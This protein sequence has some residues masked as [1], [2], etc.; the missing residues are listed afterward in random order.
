MAVVALLAGCTSPLQQ[1]PVE[2]RHVPVPAEAVVPSASVKPPPGIE[3]AGKPGYYT[4]KPGDT[5]FHISVENKQSEQD[6]IAWNN[7]GDPNKIE[8]GQVLRVAPPMGDT[9]PASPAAATTHAVTSVART[10]SKP[11][12]HA[13]AAKPASGAAPAPTSA[14]E[15]GAEGIE[16]SWPANGAVIEGFEESG[17]KG[18][19]LA[20]RLHDPVYAAADGHV[21]YA[22]SGLKSYGKVVVVQH[23]SNF[24]SVYAHNDQLLVQEGDTVKRGQKIAEMG[25]TDADR[26]ELH[27]QLRD[28]LGHNVDPTKVLPVR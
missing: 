28:K 12:E 15:P 17:H 23:G 22:G 7:L 4:V 16:W 13:S 24:V 1:A 20:G 18:I 10:E 25:S 6:I 26:V 2:S 8:V 9:T 19:T 11:V 14:P 3:N 27:F 5:V 21:M